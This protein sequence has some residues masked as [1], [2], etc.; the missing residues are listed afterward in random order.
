MEKVKV[1]FY[2]ASTSKVK[3]DAVNEVFKNKAEIVCLNC[4]SLVSE[5]PKEQEETLLG[6]GNRMAE[7]EKQIMDIEQRI[8]QHSAYIIS[9]ENGIFKE[10]DDCLAYDKAI[11]YIKFKY[12][13]NNDDT[14]YFTKCY[15]F[16]TDKVYF[17]CK[18]YDKSVETGKTV[19]KLL[20]EEYGYDS[21][22]WHIHFSKFTR[23]ELIVNALNKYYYL[24]PNNI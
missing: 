1:I 6:C 4:A 10:L 22:D 12:Y 23:K 24:L 15:T 21:N 17:P 13:K 5:Q 20:N 16:S 8:G 3:L 14:E 11:I 19:G 18:Y 2:I 9:I 7:A